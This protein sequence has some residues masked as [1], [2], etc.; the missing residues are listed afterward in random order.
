MSTKEVI[1]G[2]LLSGNY[3]LSYHAN[4]RMAER[5]V[6]RKDIE[7]CAQDAEVMTQPDGTFLVLGL[8]SKNEDL[9]I[10]C[11]YENGTLIVTIY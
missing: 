9:T 2:D 4:L 1:K 10:V 7:V 3:R 5:T 8:D 6:S 11:A